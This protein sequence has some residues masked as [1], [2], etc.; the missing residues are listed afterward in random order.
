MAPRA[1]RVERLHLTFLGSSPDADWLRDRAALLEHLNEP[2]PFCL[3][4]RRAGST[5]RC[6]REQ[7]AGANA[8]AAR[9]DGP[10]VKFRLILN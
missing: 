2:R 6:G 8:A 1:A 9:A 5:G 4:A 7:R 10:P 3:A